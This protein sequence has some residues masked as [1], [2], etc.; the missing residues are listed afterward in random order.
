MLPN[1]R[2]TEA[3]VQ[4]DGTA[5]VEPLNGV[6]F[7]L[8]PKAGNVGGFPVV[9]TVD[10]DTNR[11]VR[12]RGPGF[13]RDVGAIT[14]LEID[15]TLGNG[16]AGDLWEVTVLPS[17]TSYE[18][19]RPR[20]DAQGFL[21]T[22]PAGSVVLFDFNSD[23][24]QV[25]F[26]Q[27]FGSGQTGAFTVLPSNATAIVPVAGVMPAFDVSRFNNVALVI[28]QLGTPLEWIFTPK[29]E[30]TYAELGRTL[31]TFP[32][33][34]LEDFGS[35]SW[36]GTPG[37]IHLGSSLSQVNDFTTWTPKKLTHVRPNLEVLVNNVDWTNVAWGSTY[38]LRLALVA[39]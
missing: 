37:L 12:V 38:S 10:G 1:D 34:G 17:A 14:K 19:A 18:E 15:T 11:K 7:S 16:K 4:A 20:S 25:P 30:I 26:L 29:L 22:R 8:Q 9:V 21:Q 5:V 3:E 35:S 2:T 27:A 31:E 24:S 6:G 33:G 39:W 36:D 32:A 23:T 13:M 28:D